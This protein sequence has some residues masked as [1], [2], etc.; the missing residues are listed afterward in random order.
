[1]RLL[2]FASSIGQIIGADFLMTLMGMS[3]AFPLSRSLMMFDISSAV[4][5]DRKML[6]MRGFGMK[7]EKWGVFII[8]SPSLHSR[9][10][11]KL[12]ARDTKYLLNSLAIIRLSTI[13]LLSI[14]NCGFMVWLF[15]PLISLIIFHVFHC[16]TITLPSSVTCHVAHS[17]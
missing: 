10:L 17:S 8:G 16:K 13:R 7:L 2:K 12:E 4:Q 1:M 5:S 3:L 6:L 11:F 15:F 9:V 14:M